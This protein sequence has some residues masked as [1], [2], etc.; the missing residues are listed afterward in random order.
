MAPTRHHRHKA[1]GKT[2]HPTTRAQTKTGTASRRYA[3]RPTTK[4][5]KPPARYKIRR[6]LGERRNGGKT[7][8][9]LQWLPSWETVS[10]IGGG[11]QVILD[12]WAEHRKS[13]ETFEFKPKTSDA[14]ETT[15]H[16]LRDDVSTENDNEEMLRQMF[17]A[18]MEK[19]KDLMAPQTD[20]TEEF[21]EGEWAFAAGQEIKANRIASN[22]SGSPTTATGI[23]RKT[24][25]D[26][27]NLYETDSMPENFNDGTL[28]YGSIRLHYLG[29]IDAT[30]LKKGVPAK[31]S[32][33]PK[34]AWEIVL[35][36]F[37]QGMQ[38]IDAESMT[39][40]KNF[41]QHFKWLSWWVEEA[42]TFAPYVLK[43]PWFLLLVRFFITSDDLGPFLKK[44]TGIILSNDWGSDSRDYLIATYLDEVDFEFRCPHDVQ[45]TY[46]HLRD[47]FR[48]CAEDD[49]PVN[50][51]S[52]ENGAQEYVEGLG[53]I[54]VDAED[55][56]DLD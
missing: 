27:K 50:D 54:M 21:K 12:E 10:S 11:R 41:E 38:N 42:V 35:P 33:S 5:P 25:E 20:W 56:E 30:N 13:K 19:V 34:F 24:Y 14:T 49:S 23:L 28:K 18:V 53:H 9:L 16:M 32:R 43:N 39:D 7:E 52:E 36:L 3:D 29:Q 1:P 48:D 31:Q 40:G 46:L 26:M 4:K 37:Q 45:D 8:Y 55:D 51:S 6:I 22:G 15:Y 2:T 17:E 44:K 47:F